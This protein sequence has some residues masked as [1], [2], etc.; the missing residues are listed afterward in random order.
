M[1]H[2]ANASLNLTT[3]VGSVWFPIQAG[4]APYGATVCLADKCIPA[5]EVLQAR[6]WLGSCRH[7]GRLTRIAVA[8]ETC[9]L[10]ALPSSILPS[11]SVRASAGSFPASLIA[12]SVH[13]CIALSQSTPL[14]AAWNVSGIDGDGKEEAGVGEDEEKEKDRIH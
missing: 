11:T 7:C 6:R 10:R 4:R 8:R 3:V 9:I 2:L 13:F 12:L 14:M 5:V 1:I